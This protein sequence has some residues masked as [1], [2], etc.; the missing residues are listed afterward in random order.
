MF[1]AFLVLA[2]LGVAAYFFYFRK[3]KN[4]SEQY[5]VATPT[6]DPSVGNPDRPDRQQKNPA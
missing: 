2:F 1:K 5:T 4:K 6:N 3:R